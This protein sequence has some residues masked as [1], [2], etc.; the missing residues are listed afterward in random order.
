LAPHRDTYWS[1]MRLQRE[2]L[3]SE[4]ILE[5]LLAAH[6]GDLETLREFYDRATNRGDII[7]SAE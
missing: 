2:A 4:R 7:E 6:T 3:E 1:E 5:R